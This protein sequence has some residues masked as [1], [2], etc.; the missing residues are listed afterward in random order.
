M[1]HFAFQD[2]KNRSHIGQRIISVSKPELEFPPGLYRMSF[3]NYLAYLEKK[4]YKLS[5]FLDFIISK[6][7]I[8][9]YHLTH[10]DKDKDPH[11]RPK[12]TSFFASDTLRIDMNKDISK[13][14]IFK[15]R[16]E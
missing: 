11:K 5:K 16:Y 15:N 1:V 9:I 4:H 7:L 14:N 10:K 8:S 6:K 2:S 12:K 13:K 3:N